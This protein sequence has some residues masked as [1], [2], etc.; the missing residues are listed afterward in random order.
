[1]HVPDFKHEFRISPHLLPQVLICDI[2]KVTE[3]APRDVVG[4]PW[5]KF[6]FNAVFEE[7]PNVAMVLPHLLSHYP[8]PCGDIAFQ[9]GLGKLH[10]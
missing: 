9:V 7:L 6:G 10:G 4:V 2:H 3:F 1:M 5:D 8:P